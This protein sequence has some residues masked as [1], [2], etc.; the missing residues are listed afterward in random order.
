M[1]EGMPKIT[2]NLISI[3]EKVPTNWERIYK[4]MDVIFEQLRFET[5][6]K[7]LEEIFKFTDYEIN[8]SNYMGHAV[9]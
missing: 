7:I 3:S 4:R 9:K 8:L 6:Q 5:H 1:V 2:K